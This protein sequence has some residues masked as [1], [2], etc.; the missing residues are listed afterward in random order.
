MNISCCDGLQLQVIRYFIGFKTWFRKGLTLNEVVFIATSLSIMDNGAPILSGRLISKR[1][2]T[3]R[4]INEP[5][6]TSQLGVD[7]TSAQLSS[8]QKLTSSQNV[9]SSR[10]S[11]TSAQWSSSPCIFRHKRDDV[12]HNNYAEVNYCAEDNNCA[13]VNFS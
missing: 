13:E 8:S 7:V 5:N 1:V 4:V 2:S 3:P 9:T 10:L 12:R 6:R 11:L